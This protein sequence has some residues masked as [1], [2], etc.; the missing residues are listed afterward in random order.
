MA[1]V[2]ACGPGAVLSH[3]S[4]VE[5]RGLV[6]DRGGPIDVTASNRRGR[7]PR[8]IVPHRD[9]CLRAV[10]RD[11]VDRVP[12]VTLERALLDFAA[13]API[14]ELRTAIG[15]AEV[16]RAFDHAAARALIRRSRG[17]RGV[18]RFRLVLDEIRPQTKR[19]RSEME[20][21]FLR[22]CNR[23]DLPE[24][25]VNVR[26][27][28]GDRQLKPDFLWR[29]AGLIMEADSRRF[30]ATDSAFRKDNWREQ[31]LE[32]AG[33]RVSHCT[34]EQVERNPRDLAGIIRGLLQIH[35]PMGLNREI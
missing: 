12:C 17:R 20:R 10:D 21:L 26:L 1:A 22:M 24:P 23:F 35:S 27:H 11:V 16:L 15:E 8:K 34:W 30:H 29:Q 19:T 7:A 4:A 25:E 31:K 14:W 18:A 5:I 3:R 9:D 28:V 33:W 32:L 13:V 2:L 6:E